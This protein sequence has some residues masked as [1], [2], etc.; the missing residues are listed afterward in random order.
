MVNK[1]YLLPVVLELLEVWATH[2]VLLLAGHQR[3]LILI[4]LLALKSL[5]AC[6]LLVMKKTLLCNLAF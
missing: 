1:V 5:S 6:R 4:T 3:R 2:L